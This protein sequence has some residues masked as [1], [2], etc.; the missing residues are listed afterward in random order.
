MEG[1]QRHSIGRPPDCRASGP[2][3]APGRLSP[4]P[5]DLQHAPRAVLVYLFDLRSHAQIMSRAQAQL[6][7]FR[8]SGIDA[9]AVCVDRGLAGALPDHVRSIRSNAPRL[10][11]SFS[12]SRKLENYL[13]HTHPDVVVVRYGFATAWLGR[14]ARRVPLLLEIHA[15]DTRERPARWG[16]RAYATLSSLAFRRRLLRSAAGAMFVTRAIS[17]L[18]AFAELRGPRAVIPNGIAVPSEPLPVPANDRPIVGYS[19]GF[20]APWQGLDRLAE[21]AEALP[22]F[23]FRLVVPARDMAT[24]VEG[25]AVQIA[26]AA[27]SA[28]YHSLVA[29]FDVALG[30]LALDRKGIDVAS[31]LKVRESV[32]LGIPTLLFS[33]D[34][35]LDDVDHPTLRTLARGSWEPAK[36]APAVREFVERAQGSRIPDELRSMVDIRTKAENYAALITSAISQVRIGQPE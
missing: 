18:P 1:S 3:D 29:G 11:R 36:I 22:E 23:D 13:R 14:V 28:E 25:S 4:V 10:V 21:L 33:R 17:G 15:D 6:Q 5:T 26:V 9:S 34:E 35:D 32:S 24:A 8:D 7:V 16:A 12:E 2:T 20:D 19:V 27:S 30:T 31:A